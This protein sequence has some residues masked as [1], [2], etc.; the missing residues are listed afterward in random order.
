VN[1]TLLTVKAAGAVVAEVNTE[2]ELRR[3]EK[4][5]RAKGTMA[6]RVVPMITPVAAAV[7]LARRVALRR[8][9]NPATEAP[10]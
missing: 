2:D 4:E 6:V 10:A 8:P 5:P 3:P 9:R 7:V 1:P